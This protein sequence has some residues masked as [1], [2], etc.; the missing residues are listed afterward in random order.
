MDPI[1][2]SSFLVTGGAGFIGSH[3]VDALLDREAKKVFVLD[4]LSTGNLKNLEYASRFPNFEFIE[5]D[6]LN[7]PLVEK[8]IREV[9]YVFHEA[10]LGSVPRSL[11]DP[12]STHHANITGSLNVFWACKLHPV[13]RVIYA[14]SSS[15]YGD[16]PTLPKEEEKLGLPLSPYAVSKRTME[17]YAHVFHHHFRVPVIG[18]RYF[19]VF[20]PRQ[21]PDGAYAAA[22]P[23][24]IRAMLNNQPPTIYGDGTQKRDFTYVENVVEANL[25]AVLSPH[26][27]EGKIYNIGC[28]TSTSVLEVFQMIKAY[29]K[30]E[31]EPIF[32]PER[33][34]DI[35]NSLA[36]IQKARVELG[37]N[38]IVSFEEGLKKTISW[39][40]HIFHHAR[41]ENYFGSG[42]TF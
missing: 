3:I 12:I 37:Y 19:N 13:K 26:A 17:L 21:N 5:G 38:P 29:L 25:A 42:G 7:F 40:Q 2:R 24:F 11:E 18:L 22:I 20:G 33:P 15:V 30:C 34:G 23:K 10:A 31:I 35:K 9:D 1:K 8:L 27:I 32:A 39:Y 6:I 14:S 36:N 16:E 28:G 41:T 4:N